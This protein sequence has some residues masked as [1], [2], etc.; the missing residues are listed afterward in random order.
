MPTVAFLLFPLSSYMISIFTPH[1]RRL[2]L[3][4][5]SS[6]FHKHHHLW[7]DKETDRWSE[8]QTKRVHWQRLKL[9]N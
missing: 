2:V 3:I 9:A 6:Y 7:Y 8:G 4:S 5:N 1:I